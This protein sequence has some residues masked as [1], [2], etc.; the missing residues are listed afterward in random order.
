M[1]R[2]HRITR[3]AFTA[4]VATALSA[5]GALPAMLR[6]EQ[7]RA[8]LEDHIRS[9]EH[10]GVLINE[11]SLPGEGRKDDVVPRHGS[12]IQVS[13]DRWLILYQTHGFRGVDDERS[14]VYQL[15]RG[16]PDGPVVKEGFLARA[17]ADWHPPGDGPTSPGGDRCYFKQHGHM[18]AFGVPKGAL[19][20]GRPAPHANL[21]VAKWRVLGRIWDRQRD[22]LEHASRDRQLMDRTQNVEW[23]QF[24]L[25]D[26]E[27]DIEIVQ[28]V[29]LLRQA[30]YEQGAAFCSAPAAWM[31]QSFTPPVPWN[32]DR[33]E[34]ADCNHFDRGRLAVL[35]YR[36]QPQLGRYEWVQTGPMIADPKQGLFEASLAQLGGQWVIGARLA[37]GG[38]VAWTR[39]DDPFTNVPP[40]ILV[41]EPAGG[42]PRTAFVCADGVLRLF[43]GDEASSP[44]RNGRDPLYCWDVDPEEN[45]AYSN[46]RVIF[47]SVQ[48]RIPI[49]RAASPKVDFCVLLPQHAAVQLAM[50]SLCTR[51]YNHPYENRPGI[52]AVTAEEKTHCA[53]YYARIH[54]RGEPARVWEF[55]DKSQ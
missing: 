31:N 43:T 54:Y 37:N 52:P 23:V 46:R 7:D 10:Q 6:A 26:Q 5:G 32:Q 3:R 25:N 47:D 27:D 50:H 18:V 13:R 41:K 9:I 49:R 39:C 11:C 17:Q 53:I 2:Q 12:G 15:R 4:S 51:S 34:W 36:Y 48:A 24:R 22:Y 21:F 20:N 29:R 33:T 19:I 8:K 45:F 35:K 1:S 44:Y 40:P 42:S 16:A 28:P 14:I 38:G 55:G 30:G